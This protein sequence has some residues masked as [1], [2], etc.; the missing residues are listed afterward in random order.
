MPAPPVAAPDGGVAAAVGR[1]GGPRR[2]AWG[3]A[4][5]RG[6]AAQ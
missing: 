6:G 1:R 5:F 3:A 2:A 4:P